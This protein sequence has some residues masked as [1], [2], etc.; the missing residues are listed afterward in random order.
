MSACDHVSILYTNNSNT[1]TYFSSSKVDKDTHTQAH[2]H[3][4]THMYMC[5]DIQTAWGVFLL[6][7][8]ETELELKNNLYMVTA[9][10][11]IYLVIFVDQA[12]F[13]TFAYF[14]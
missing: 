13:Q 7:S 1:I 9:A 6:N 10:F 4:Q 2:V 14:I 5:W 12:L 8:N 11:I 3:A